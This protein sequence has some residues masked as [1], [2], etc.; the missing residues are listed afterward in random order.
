[1]LQGIEALEGY[2]DPST[3]GA[4]DDKESK[5]ASDSAGVAGETTIW[6]FM[7]IKYKQIASCPTVPFDIRPTIKSHKCLEKKTSTIYK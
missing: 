7:A 5:A 2:I 1:M 4:V 6:Y 3:G